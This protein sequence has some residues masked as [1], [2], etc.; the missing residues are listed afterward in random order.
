[1]ASLVAVAVAG[2]VWLVQESEVA[3]AGDAGGGRLLARS[4]HGPSRSC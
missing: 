3:G 2:S 4:G 1:M